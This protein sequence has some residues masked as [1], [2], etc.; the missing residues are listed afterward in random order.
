MTPEKRIPELDIARGFCVLS[1]IAVHFIYDLTEV[2]FLLPPP[3]RVFLFVKNQGGILF[4]LLSGI[5]AT[6]GHRCVKRGSI[7][8]ACAALVSIATALA[9]TPV[10]FGVLHCLGFCMVLWMLFRKLPTPALLFFGI[11]FLLAGAAFRRIR[12]CAPFLY[13]L[14]LIRADFTSADFFPLFPYLGYFLSG[15]VLGK[16]LYPLRRSLLPR[17]SFRDPLSRF[18]RFCGRQALPLYLLHQPVLLF[19][20]EAAYYFGGNFYES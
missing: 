14:G 5:S 2:Y 12:I 6:L 8:L 1:M 20:I 17:L 15:A 7:V 10:R 11:L 9:G 4:F 3:N 19:A 18:F 16:L 13:P